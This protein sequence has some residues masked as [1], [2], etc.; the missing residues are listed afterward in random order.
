MQQL[1]TEPL[2]F[3][4]KAITLYTLPD[5]FSVRHFLKASHEV[6]VW[7]YRA[8]FSL[9]VLLVYLPQGLR[10]NSSP[11]LNLLLGP[12]SPAN[13]TDSI[14]TNCCEC[15]QLKNLFIYPPPPPPLFIFWRPRETNQFEILW[16]VKEKRG[17]K[18]KNNPRTGPEGENSIS[19]LLSL[20]KTFKATSFVD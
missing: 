8:C 2:S 4:G 11:L 20:V 18:R 10:K 3:Q 15:N 19:P 1:L 12:P 16:R 6:W 5:L 7:S 13:K 14:K 17:G 9:H